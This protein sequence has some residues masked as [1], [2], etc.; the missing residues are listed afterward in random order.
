MRVDD[1]INSERAK[2]IEALEEELERL[3]RFTEEFAS[4]ARLRP[5]ERREGDLVRLVA[6]FVETYHD[7]WDNLRF[8]QEGDETVSVPFDRDMLRQVLA[9]LCD[10]SSRAIG[11]TVPRLC[12]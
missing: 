3:G 12:W 2:A 10:N 4:F 7:A 8:V 5:P 11:M 1:S 6:D 9:Y